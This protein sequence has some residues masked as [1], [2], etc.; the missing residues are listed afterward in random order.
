MALCQISGVLKAPDGVAL[1]A[2]KVTF[3]RRGG[4][5][6]LGERTVVPRGVTVTT[7][8]QGQLSVGLF[9]GTYEASA[10]VGTTRYSF[11]VGVPDEPTAVLRDLIGQAGPAPVVLGPFTVTTDGLVPAPQVV[12]GGRYLREDGTWAVPAGG[13]GGGG[14]VAWDDVTDKPE[15]F[16]PEAHGHDT[17]T[18]SDAGFMSPAQVQALEAN[19]LALDGLLAALEAI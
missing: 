2:A 7:D 16:P 9:P 15:T 17:A 11:S 19:T 12:S 3:S 6:G 13:G 10:L 18:A 5:V 1:I 4:V 8:G 14:S